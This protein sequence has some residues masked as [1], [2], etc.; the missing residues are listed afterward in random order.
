MWSHKH[1]F[2][3]CLFLCYLIMILTGI[4]YQSIDHD[5][6]AHGVGDSPSFWDVPQNQADPGGVGIKQKITKPCPAPSQK[7]VWFKGG[8][9]HKLYEPVARAFHSRGYSRTKEWE[10]AQVLWTDQPNYNQAGRLFQKLKPWQRLNQMPNTREWDDKDRMAAHM[11]QYFQEK[12]QPLSNSFPESYLLHEPQDFRR[13]Q[14]RLS[15]QNGLEIPWVLKRPTIN[16]G[17]G[18]TVVGPHSKELRE[19]LNRGGPYQ[20][21][22]V[23]Q[24]FICDEMTY[25][26]RKF[27]FRIFWMVASVD[28][29]LVLYHA[30]NNYV[31][32]GHAKYDESNFNDTKSHLT[33]HT[34][35]A[36]E[37]KATWDEFRVFVEEHQSLQGDRLQH[38]GKDPFQHVQ[39][40]IKS[41]ISFLADAYKN[42]TFHNND[43]SSENAFSLHAADMIIDNDLDV[44]IIEGTDG[45]GKDEDYDFRIV[46]H[47]AIFGSVV[48]IL[49]DVTARQAKGV[50][51][52]VHDMH[53]KGILGAFEPVYDGKMNWMY[54]YIDYER[55]KVT[56]KKGCG[57]A[58][59]G[60]KKES[61]VDVP[62]RNIALRAVTAALPKENI[63]GA[64][65][66]KTFYMEGRTSRKGEPIARAFRRHGW[67]PVDRIELAQVVYDRQQPTIGKGNSAPIER[68]IRPW[69][70]HNRFPM[71]LE[72]SF[73]RKPFLRKFL[74]KSK[75][76]GVV[77][78]PL[79]YNGRSFTVNVYVLILSLEPL[80]VYYHDGYVLIPHSKEDQREFLNSTSSSNQ[81]E[82]K[83]HLIWRGSWKS[84][85]YILNRAKELSNNTA[86]PA[87]PMA[88]VQN[89][90]KRSM[91]QFTASFAKRANSFLKLR[92]EHEGSDYPPNYFSLF[93]AVFQIDDD[94][95]TFLSDVDHLAV[96]YGEDFEDIVVMHNDLFGAA[97]TLLETLN[98]TLF[99]SKSRQPLKNSSNG[100]R[101]LLTTRELLETTTNAMGRYELLIY[102]DNMT[103]V[104]SSAISS[105][106]PP[107]SS[108]SLFWSFG[109]SWPKQAVEC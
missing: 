83:E 104:G 89:Q 31:R 79:T 37:K 80:V 35:G 21:R 23:A 45:P 78:N 41:I 20:D 57:G 74:D 90:L 105:Q 91:V 72:Q 18:V 108:S 19:I 30:K 100:S 11:K 106:I 77:C 107:S 9:G 6:A 82:T 85:E 24:R 42:I 94:L 53:E 93:R 86:L 39:N 99:C 88:H 63:V 7:L 61:V 65:K 16:Q 40:Q 1:T 22:M 36:G 55:L 14:N 102:N 64:A 8:V 12:Q 109:Y 68:K 60:G 15:Q 92:H 3:T 29:L 46:M 70:F 2:K 59:F 34:F 73:F 5:N 103:N 25:D 87:D 98:A 17:K 54:E 62:M 58:S 49:D 51:L 13:F 33:T 101:P 28:P 66:L 4:L 38:L 75:K 48:D 50:P 26:G 47:D 97:L 32:I 81:V 67:T 10:E 95:N 52:D 76:D 44:Y 71:E 27:D 69:Q 43:F 56:H 96:T 84:L